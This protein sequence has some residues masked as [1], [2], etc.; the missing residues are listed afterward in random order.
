MDGIW[1]RQRG[2]VNWS[3]SQAYKVAAV[4]GYDDWITDNGY[5]RQN[6]D[7]DFYKN[8]VKVLNVSVD[9][10]LGMN[11][12][13]IVAMAMEDSKEKKQNSQTQQAKQEKLVDTIVASKI[14]N[15][16]MYATHWK[17]LVKAVKR[18]LVN[19]QLQQTLFFIYS[20]NT[21]FAGGN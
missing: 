16:T 9:M 3:A 15:K 4:L 13:R 6:A 21:L 18:R 14:E 12:T 1:K 2:A 11:G 5:I 7:C 8:R 20:E 17:Q 19:E 10:G